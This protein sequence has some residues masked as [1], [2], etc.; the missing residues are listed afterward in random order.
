MKINYLGTDPVKSLTV[1]WKLIRI[2]KRHIHEKSSKGHRS[3]FSF[4]PVHGQKG[5]EESFFC[6]YQPC[7]EGMQPMKEEQE[8]NML[9]TW[10]LWALVVTVTYFSAHFLV[11]LFR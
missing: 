10:S 11:T 7:K 4:E 5:K 3:T 8:I 9:D 2:V 1:A 6:Y